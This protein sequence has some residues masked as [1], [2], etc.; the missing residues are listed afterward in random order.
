MV[1][2]VQIEWKCGAKSLNSGGGGGGVLRKRDQ[3]KK[4]KNGVLIF[5]SHPLPHPLAVFPVCAIPN[6]SR[7]GLKK[8]RGD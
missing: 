7:T 3:M 5:R 6:M 1:L 8:G 2:G 4:E